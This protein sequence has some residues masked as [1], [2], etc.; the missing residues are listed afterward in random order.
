[1]L[2]MARIEGPQLSGSSASK[3]DGLTASVK[4]MTGTLDA[5]RTQ[6]RARLAGSS[7]SKF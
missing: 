3:K 5:V 7:E 1:M 4:I 6:Q 2:S